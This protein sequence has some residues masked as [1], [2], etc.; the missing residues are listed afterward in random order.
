M[1]PE[2]VEKEDGIKQ[3]SVERKHQETLISLHEL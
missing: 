3:E 1:E 2:K